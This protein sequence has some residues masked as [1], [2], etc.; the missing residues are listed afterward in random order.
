MHL[1]KSYTLFEFTLWSRRKLYASLACGS[2]PVVL[3]QLLGLKWLS[4]PVSVVVLLGTATSF[5]VGFRNVQTYGR[6]VEAQQIWTDILNGSRYLGVMSRDFPSGRAAGR[7]LILRH[8]AWLTALRYQLRSPRIWENAGK[9][10]NVEYRK[11]YRIPEWETPLEQALARYLPQAEIASFL[12]AGSRATWLLGTQAATIKRL[13]DAGEISN[14]FYL[15]LLGSIRGF[16]A[17]QGRAERVKDYPYP[18]QYEVINK[19]F[20]RTFCLLLPFGILTE[21]EKLNASVSGVMHGNMIWLVIPFST[22]IS[23]MYLVLEQVGESTENPFEGNPNDVPMAQICRKI[24][25][26]LMDLLG[27]KSDVVEPTAEHGIVL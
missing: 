21:F 27:E 19:L 6:A 20:V 23:W 1:G 10:A 25:R 11:Y 17:Q 9:V 22:M 18:R 8:C 3:Y 26:E 15:E 4:I 5:I 13:L 12:H 16:F 14:A 24:E 7:E 2:L